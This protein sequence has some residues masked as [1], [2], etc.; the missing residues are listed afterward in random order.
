[1][2]AELFVGN[3]THNQYVETGQ[4]V[5]KRESEILKMQVFCKQ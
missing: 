5:K 1:M 3:G 2:H 4:Q